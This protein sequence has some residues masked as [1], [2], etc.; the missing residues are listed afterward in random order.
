[1]L[2]YPSSDMPL[3]K[4]LNYSYVLPETWLSLYI[5]YIMITADTEWHLHQYNLQATK[6]SD[7]IR[8]GLLRLALVSELFLKYL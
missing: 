4:L 6:K 2:H 3:H 7:I 1:M 8:W 5:I